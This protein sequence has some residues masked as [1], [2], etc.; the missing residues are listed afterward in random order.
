MK[1]HEKFLLK[2]S[3]AFALLSAITPTVNAMHI[4]EGYLPAAT[5]WH[6]G[7]SACRF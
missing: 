2:A 7:S 6:G 1:K 5:A 3:I 4:M